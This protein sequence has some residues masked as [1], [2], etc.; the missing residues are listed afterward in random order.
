[1][2]KPMSAA[3]DS[4]HLYSAIVP[5]LLSTSHEDTMWYAKSQQLGTK[6]D[7]K[8]TQLWNG[9]YEKTILGAIKA[10]HRSPVSLPL[11]LQADRWNYGLDVG[12]L[13]LST[14]LTLRLNVPF[15]KYSKRGWNGGIVR[16]HTSAGVVAVASIDVRCVVYRVA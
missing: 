11:L 6:I 8:N 4:R 12:A 5:E 3:A 2:S 14:S 16:T 13:T 9:L 15:K 7:D 1:M 10:I